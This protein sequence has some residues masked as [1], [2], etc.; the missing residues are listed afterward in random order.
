[1]CLKFYS[2]LKRVCITNRCQPLDTVSRAVIL[3]GL[4]GGVDI[5]HNRIQ[6]IKTCLVFVDMAHVWAP[7]DEPT[8]QYRYKV[9]LWLEQIVLVFWFPGHMWMPF[10][11]TMILAREVQ[12]MAIWYDTESIRRQTAIVVSHACAVNVR[13]VNTW[14]HCRT[15]SSRSPS[16]LYSECNPAD[17]GEKANIDKWHS[18]SGN[19]TFPFTCLSVPTR[20]PRCTC[21][22]L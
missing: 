7:D 10:T 5:G 21:T 1:M 4:T 11:E 16:W 8:P 18:G 9:N 19:Y 3:F 20:C 6:N 2:N 15:S 13:D 14:V 12:P 22:T 17:Q